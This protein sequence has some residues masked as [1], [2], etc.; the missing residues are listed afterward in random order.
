MLLAGTFISVLDFFIV[1]VAIPSLQRNLHASSAGIEM[2]V[3]GFALA[4]GSGLILGGRLG[5]IFGRRR[6][7]AIGLILSRSPLLSAEWRRT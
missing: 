7:F 2:V 1:N 6:L 5:D 3:A 4:F